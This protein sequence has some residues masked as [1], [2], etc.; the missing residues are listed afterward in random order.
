MTYLQSKAGH[1]VH[2]LRFQTLEG[3][4]VRQYC[5]D[6]DCGHVVLH[7]AAGKV[8]PPPPDIRMKRKRQPKK[9]AG[10]LF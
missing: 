10:P 7:V 4:E 8:S 9:I 5:A 2:Q 6:P 1:H 3:G